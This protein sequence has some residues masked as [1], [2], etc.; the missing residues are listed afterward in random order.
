M[1]FPRA[2]PMALLRSRRRNRLPQPRPAGRKI[3][4]ASFVGHPGRKLPPPRARVRGPR[5]WPECQRFPLAEAGI[6][7]ATGAK[8][9]EARLDT[10]GKLSDHM[11]EQGQ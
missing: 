6:N 11:G 3:D 7:G 9:I 5:L 4:R 10:L 1:R 2:G 8:L